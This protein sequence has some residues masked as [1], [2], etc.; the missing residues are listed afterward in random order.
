M[1]FAKNAVQELKIRVPECVC[2]GL[3]RRVE[4]FTNANGNLVVNE[5]ESLEAEYSSTEKND[6]EITNFLVA[7]WE[8]HIRA[9]LPELF[10]TT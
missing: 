5:F 4:I 7:F 8:K 6:L 3:V 10:I 1:A 2:D 9:S